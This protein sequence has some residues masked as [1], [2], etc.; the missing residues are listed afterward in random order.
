[1]RKEINSY[2]RAY[3]KE[4]NGCYEEAWNKVYKAFNKQ[5]HIYIKARAK[6]RKCRPLDMVEQMGMLTAL[7]A[8]AI[9]ILN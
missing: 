5:N 2:I 3:A 1:M 7:F 6:H 4:N 8:V 9:E